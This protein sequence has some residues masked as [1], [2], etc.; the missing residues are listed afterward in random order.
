MVFDSPV[1]V[2]GQSRVAIDGDIASAM[3][4]TDVLFCFIGPLGGA[5][6]SVEGNIVEAQ[7]GNAA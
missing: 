4:L 5:I 1:V 6:D 7:L 3:G 2:L